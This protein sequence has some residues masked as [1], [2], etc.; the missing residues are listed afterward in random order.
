MLAQELG[1][2]KNSIHFVLRDHLNKCKLFFR[3]IPYSLSEEQKQPLIH[4]I[5]EVNRFTISQIFCKILSQVMKTVLPYRFVDAM[6]N[7]RA[8]IVNKPTPKKKGQASLFI[9]FQGYS[10]EKQVRSKWQK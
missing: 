2:S 7:F 9:R 3:F 5:K 4:H 1:V 6:M 8:E 10:A